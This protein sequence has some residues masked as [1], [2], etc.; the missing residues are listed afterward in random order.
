MS[1]L[2]ESKYVNTFWCKG[3]TDGFTFSEVHSIQR[4][5]RQDALKNGTRYIETDVAEYSLV[6]Y[7]RDR[8]IENICGDF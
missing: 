6:K 8:C 7:F 4:T 3:D 5:G 1:Y 2:K